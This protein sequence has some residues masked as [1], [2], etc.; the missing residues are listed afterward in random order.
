MTEKKSTFGL[1]KNIAS[2]LT[3]LFGW[4]SGLV[5]FLVEKNDKDIRFHAVQSIIFFGAL[6]IIVII[7][8]VGWLVSPFLGLVG[9]ISWVVLLVKAYRGEKLKLPVVG[10]LAEK[11]RK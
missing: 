2:A 11:W 5:F 8:V 10:E 9:L 4:L 6:N 3:Y 1:D 7:P